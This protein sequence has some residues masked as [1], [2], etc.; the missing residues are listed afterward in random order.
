MEKPRDAISNSKNANY[1]TGLR[2]T[3]AWAVLL[4]SWCGDEW[5]ENPFAV[6]EDQIDPYAN[7][8]NW[9]PVLAALYS[10]REWEYRC[11]SWDPDET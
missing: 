10:D 7:C 5:Y 8:S 6:R 9:T 3:V 1:F 2:A 4:L 11:P